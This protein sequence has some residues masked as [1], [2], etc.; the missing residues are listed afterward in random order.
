VLV[1]WWTTGQLAAAAAV[2]DNE[3]TAGTD[4]PR[5]ELLGGI[6]MVEVRVGMS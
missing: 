3:D 5:R 4:K 2:E 1:D 6:R